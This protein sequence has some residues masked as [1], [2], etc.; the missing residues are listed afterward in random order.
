MRTEI[1]IPFAFDTKP[2]EDELQE[3]G[4]QEVMARIIKSAEES[5]LKQLPGK[6]SGLGYYYDS[7]PRKLSDINWLKIVNDRIDKAIEE[8]IE[9]I[10]DE[11]ALLLVKRAGRKKSWREVLAEI[12]EEQD[13]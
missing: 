8:H 7:T 2:I 9:E 5:M 3:H 11:A 12:K 6:E 10:V 13:G 1:T 4:Y